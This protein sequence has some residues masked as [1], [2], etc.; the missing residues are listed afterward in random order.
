MPSSLEWLLT[1]QRFMK[2]GLERIQALLERLNHPERAYKAVLVG[3]TNGKGS[4]TLALSEILRA[5]GYR[6]GRYISPHIVRFNERMVVG[7]AEIAEEEL[8]A[9]LG[10]IRPLAEE[11]GASF[12]EIVTVAAL[13]YFAR[14]SVDW[15]VLEVGLG[16]RFDATNAT[17]PELSLITSIGLDHTEI[18]GSSL[19]QIAF[20]KA[21]ILRP[22][23]VA[24]TAAEGQGLAALRKRAGEL[25]ADLRVLGEDFC[26]AQVGPDPRG[27]SFG[28]E[29]EGNHAFHTAL[30]GA[31]QARNLALAIAA[32]RE[33]GLGWEAIQQG[34]ENLWHSGRLELLSSAYGELLLDG[35]HNLDGARAL[36]QALDDHFPQRPASLVLALSRDKDAEAMARV[37]QPAFQKIVLTRYNSPRSLA[38]EELLPYFPGALAAHSPA[39]A[40]HLAEVSGGLTVVAGSLYLVGEVK[41]L[42]LGLPAEERWQ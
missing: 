30:L 6:V 19:S 36:K 42:L 26:L 21:G 32:A 22:G 39:E 33:L 31:H 10:E 18:L 38:P 9:L 40:L 20:E 41:R 23:K 25:G 35:A 34:L 37:L 7:A 14:A 5:A 2:P 16:G 29:L 27:L 8:E 17:Q 15:A 3:G 13:L 4:T 24:F 1:Q 11:T 28:L 12:F